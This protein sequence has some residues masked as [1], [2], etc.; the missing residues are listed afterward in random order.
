[1]GGKK[2]MS[3]GFSI[4]YSPLYF[5]VVFVHLKKIFYMQVLLK[6]QSGIY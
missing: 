2:S 6:K 5:S 4:P 1:M 3:L